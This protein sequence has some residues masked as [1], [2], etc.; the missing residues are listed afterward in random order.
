MYCML[1]HC[2]DVPCTVHALCNFTLLGCAWYSFV[3]QYYIRMVF[4]L[5]G[6]K[7]PF[8]LKFPTKLGGTRARAPGLYAWTPMLC[9]WRLTRQTR[10]GTR[11][12]QPTH[13]KDWVAIYRFRRACKL[14]RLRCGYS[15]ALLVHTI[16]LRIV[17]RR[18]LGE[19]SFIHLL[20]YGRCATVS[21]VIR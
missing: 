17:R 3:K 7:Y 4:N 15:S 13:N 21:T 14:Q 19:A 6:H 8:Y 18:W 1:V 20:R 9:R 16:R 10:W 12:R 11:Q 5:G 2:T